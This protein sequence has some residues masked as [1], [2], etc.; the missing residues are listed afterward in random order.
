MYLEVRK[1]KN[2]TYLYKVTSRR[3][4]KKQVKDK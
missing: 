2:N 3:V 1:T 4:N